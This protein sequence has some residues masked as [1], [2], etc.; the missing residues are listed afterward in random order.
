LDNLPCYCQH[1]GS[2]LTSLECMP[3]VQGLYTNLQENHSCMPVFN[4]PSETF[5]T[6][7]CSVMIAS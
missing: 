5:Q 7:L 4:H 1:A 6:F 3:L 2:V